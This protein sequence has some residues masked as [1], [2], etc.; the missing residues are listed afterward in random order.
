MACDKGSGSGVTGA[1]KRQDIME[2][3]IIAAVA[4][5][6]AIGRDNALMWH[7]SE[8]MKYFRKFWRCGSLIMPPHQSLKKNKSD[9]PGEYRSD[10]YAAMCGTESV[11]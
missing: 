7:I 8:D 6:R 9:S 1:E 4:D 10:F 2:K 5:N 11:R 3:C